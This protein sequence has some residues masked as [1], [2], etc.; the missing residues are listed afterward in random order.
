MKLYWTNGMSKHADFLDVFVEDNKAVATLVGDYDNLQI[1]MTFESCSKDNNGD[2][3]F[4][5][6]TDI[7]GEF[8]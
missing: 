6:C 8:I 2:W 4:I 5:N 1:H 7:Y 3:H